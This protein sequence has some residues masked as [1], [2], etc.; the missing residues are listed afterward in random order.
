MA[1]HNLRELRVEIRKIIRA[2]KS[3]DDSSAPAL[4]RRAMNV[5]KNKVDAA[6]ADLQFI[7]LKL[8]ASR[9]SQEKLGP[10]DQE[11]PDLF[12]GLTF[13]RGTMRVPGAEGGWRTKP[14]IA[15]TLDELE[16]LLRSKDRGRQ[17]SPE[18]TA[19][20]KLLRD[21]KR[22]KISPTER[23]TAANEILQNRKRK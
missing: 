6:T 5:A 17:E 21:A 2:L 16:R 4:A 9:V 23:V 22:A 19:A 3:N 12:D 1:E 8:V 13:L 14:G 7:G 11:P 18:I 20:R 10:L 15:M